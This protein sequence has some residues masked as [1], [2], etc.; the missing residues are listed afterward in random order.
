M[1]A[2]SHYQ[3]EQG[4]WF[5]IPEE[6]IIQKFEEA[7]ELLDPRYFPNIEVLS[8]S[9]C[10]VMDIQR[11]FPFIFRSHLMVSSMLYFHVKIWLV[12]LGTVNIR[13]LHLLTLLRMITPVMCT[14]IA[15]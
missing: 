10:I 3:F 9:L 5:L 13:S 6:H 7:R 4:L 15:H 8:N 2:I 12:M 1:N 14:H 11:L